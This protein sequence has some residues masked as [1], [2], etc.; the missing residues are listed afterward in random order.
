MLAPSAKIGDCDVISLEPPTLPDSEKLPSFPLD[1]FPSEIQNFI[2]EG[3]EVL[4]F[5]PDFTAATVLAA[6]S[7]AMGNCY[8][9]DMNGNYSEPGMLWILYIDDPGS[10]KSPI[11]KEV[12]APLV[13]REN[14][15]YQEFLSAKAECSKQKAQ[16]SNEAPTGGKPK[17]KRCC[18]NNLTF[19]RLVQVMEENPRG[20]IQDVDEALGYLE[21]LNRYS[22]GNDMAS[23]NSIWSQGVIDLDRKNATSSR[24]PKPFIAFVG[25]IQ[26]NMISRFLPQRSL[27]D[28]RFPRY[29]YVNK[30]TRAKKKN[31]KVF[32]QAIRARWRYLINK[33]QDLEYTGQPNMVPHEPAA[34]DRYLEWQSANVDR[35]NATSG[36]MERGLLRKYESQLSRIILI[37]QVIYDLC[38][39]RATTVISE[40]AVLN[41]IRVLEFFHAHALSVLELLDYVERH[42]DQRTAWI[43]ALSDLLPEEF[44]TGDA[45]ALKGNFGKGERSIKGALNNRSFFERTSQGHYR[46]LT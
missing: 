36:P 26:P 41:G 5:D 31:H 39:G 32:D 22:K 6:V 44:R 11:A 8:H 9:I 7:G 19:E 40:M 38:Q 45:V 33:L 3:E 37:L 34:Y 4:Q 43:E 30:R 12:L 28:G 2:R 27:H 16:E 29:L 14:E 46:K 17:R 20:V 21:N 25:N 42:P 35:I 24:V 1:V 18:V 13:A 10:L 23:Y 15:Y